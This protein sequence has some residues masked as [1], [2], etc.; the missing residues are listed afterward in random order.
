M[1]MIPIITSLTAIDSAEPTEKRPSD[2]KDA[3]ASEATA[4]GQLPF[5][6]IL[7]NMVADSVPLL[8]KPSQD[9]G[10]DVKIEGNSIALAPPQ[11]VGSSRIGVN[12]IPQTGTSSMT[13]EVENFLRGALTVKTQ[14]ND[15]EKISPSN[16]ARSVL[17][18]DLKSSQ[19]LQN[20]VGQ[21]PMELA[22]EAS[23]ERT[24]PPVEWLSGPDHRESFSARP[25]Q[26][27][28]TDFKLIQPSRQT[29]GIVIP[30]AEQ[31]NS[32]LSG[33]TRLMQL[34]AVDPELRQIFSDHPNEISKPEVLHR[35]PMQPDQHVSDGESVLRTLRNLLFSSILGNGERSLLQ[36]DIR[37]ATPESPRPMLTTEK[38]PEQPTQKGGDIRIGDG[39]G[40]SSLE[41]LSSDSQDVPPIQFKG[42]SGSLEA[43][44]PGEQATVD[45]SA[46][47]RINLKPEPLVFAGGSVS[48]T[49]HVDELKSDRNMS[50]ESLSHESNSP[51][52]KQVPQTNK[53][54]NGGQRQKVGA[55]TSKE[56]GPVTEAAKPASASSGHQES[57]PGGH[58]FTVSQPQ[59]PAAQGMV[60]VRAVVRTL[61]EPRTLPSSIFENVIAKLSGETVQ[62]MRDGVAEMRILLKPESLGEMSLKVQLRDESVV[63][64]IQAA[65]PD[66][67]AALEAN[68][69][70]LRDAL[71]A[72]GIDVQQIN[73]VG[74]GEGQAR[75]SRSQRESRPRQ[76]MRRVS[77]E[78]AEER[79]SES[80]LLGYNTIEIIM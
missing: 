27:P 64:Q 19:E 77:V 47:P 9:P 28:V 29:D 67:R 16:P 22:V 11:P 50:D 13:A 31:T 30:L 40:S 80:R 21:K 54:D 53:S 41:P 18:S 48:A 63:A 15:G 44:P 37:E 10:S 43:T 23:S 7:A 39:I 55:E 66:V 5:L 49:R 8:V 76:G 71:A 78:D 59:P 51:S 25:V 36:R 20:T 42:V 32:G 24:L 12:L 2:H 69:P 45:R 4:A 3:G 73:I 14:T 34:P 60:P 35:S 26:S 38:S 75:E 65:H 79:Q 6:P 68:I 52:K 74:A 17:P 56:A 46:Q 1:T 58:T 61:F 72:R 62:Q 57:Q 33:E 70:Q